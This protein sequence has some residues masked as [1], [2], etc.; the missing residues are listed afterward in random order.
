MFRSDHNVR[1]RART[2]LD[3]N[4]RPVA[5]GGDRL[6]ERA[7]VLVVQFNRSLSIGPNFLTAPALHMANLPPPTDA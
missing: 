5:G 7:L 3:W 2:G 4:Q 1:S 6:V